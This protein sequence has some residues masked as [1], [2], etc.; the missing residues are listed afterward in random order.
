MKAL[1]SKQEKEFKKLEEYKT[2]LRETRDQLERAKSDLDLC[3]AS[4]SR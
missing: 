2:A 4:R 3:R 1:L